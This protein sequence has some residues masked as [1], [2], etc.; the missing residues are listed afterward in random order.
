M[1]L[2][3]HCL[4]WNSFSNCLVCCLCFLN[5]PKFFFFFLVFFSIFPFSCSQ[6]QT[7]I[8]LELH[9]ASFYIR[10]DTFMLHHNDDQQ[11]RR[12][13]SSVKDGITSKSNYNENVPIF[14]H[15]FFYFIYIS[16]YSQITNDSTTFWSKLSV[17]YIYICG[18]RIRFGTN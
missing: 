9:H 5:S 10:D 1:N 6:V 18:L 14:T 4:F 11:C 15:H 8:I 7:C 16:F 2:C 13:V 12:Q 3:A 17:V